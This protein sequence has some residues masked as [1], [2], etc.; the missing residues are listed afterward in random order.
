M[1]QRRRGFSE[2]TKRRSVVV[3]PD[4]EAAMDHPPDATSLLHH[5]AALN[6]PRQ[7]AKRGL[8]TAGD[9]AAGAVRHHCRS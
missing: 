9:P 5:F 2:R 4:L 7:R 8:P 6:D 1:G 3:S